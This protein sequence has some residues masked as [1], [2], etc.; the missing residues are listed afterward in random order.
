MKSILHLKD[1]TE[2]Q[3]PLRED[4]IEKYVQDDLK[5]WKKAHPNATEQEVLDKEKELNYQ[6]RKLAG[7]SEEEIER[8]EKARALRHDMEKDNKKIGR[9][10]AGVASATQTHKDSTAKVNQAVKAKKETEAEV[11]RT[12][13]N[14]DEIADWSQKRDA[15]AQQNLE[16]SKEEAKQAKAAVA[17]SQDELHDAQKSKNDKIDQ[18]RADSAAAK[19]AKKKTDEISQ[20]EVNDDALENLEEDPEETQNQEQSNTEENNN[21]TTTES[22][23]PADTAKAALDEMKKLASQEGVI[24]PSLFISNFSKILGLMERAMQLQVKESGSVTEEAPKATEQAEATEEKAS[25]TIEKTE[26]PAE[27]KQG[28]L[29][30]RNNR[31]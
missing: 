22:V 15:E 3:I 31:S 21:D 20:E 14:A 5:K 23:P 1:D 11:E 8:R 30:G 7:Q 2:Y 9:A 10:K 17:Q 16:T 19:E 26:L 25:E 27:G 29:N 13:D 24:H 18:L 28:E 4:G 6:M 12:K